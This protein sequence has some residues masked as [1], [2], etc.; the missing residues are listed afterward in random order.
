VYGSH[1]LRQRARLLPQ[2]ATGDLMLEGD[3][4]VPLLE[5]CVQVLRDIVAIAND[6][7]VDV[8][9][10]RFR[11]ANIAAATARAIAIGGCLDFIARPSR[12]LRPLGCANRGS[13]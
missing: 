11:V 8:G 5:E 1:S 7:K 2:L 3:D 6:V 4:L 9:T 12:R 13:N 10:L